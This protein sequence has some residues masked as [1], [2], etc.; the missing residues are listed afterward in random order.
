MP[1]PAGRVGRDAAWMTG[2]GKPC[3]SLAAPSLWPEFMSAGQ[4]VYRSSR[5]PVRATRPLKITIGDFFLEHVT[6][7]GEI[8]A[9]A[10][11]HSGDAATGPTCLGCLRCGF[12]TVT[13]Q[14]SPEKS[15]RLGVILT[16]RQGSRRLSIGRLK[17][18]TIFAKEPNMHRPQY[19]IESSGTLKSSLL[20]PINFNHLYRDS[21][22]AVAVA[23]KSRTA[24]EREEI[25]VVQ[26][27]SGEVIFR[28]KCTG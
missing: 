12:V 13:T 26:I 18:E 5:R 4:C 22:L 21:S 23:A 25:R 19:R 8:F 9:G 17:E 2:D 27:P 24:P 7:G 1:R 3:V 28:T 6:F 15:A 11:P 10:T 14:V 20:L 16:C